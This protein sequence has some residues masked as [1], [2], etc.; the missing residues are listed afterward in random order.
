LGYRI[1]LSNRIVTDVK[2]WRLTEIIC[3]WARGYGLPLCG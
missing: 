2:W 1:P 3:G